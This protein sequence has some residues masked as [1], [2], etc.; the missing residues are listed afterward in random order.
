[1]ENHLRT[2]GE[3]VWAVRSWKPI[4]VLW[5]WVLGAVSA[6]AQ[7][8]TA[9]VSGTVTDQTEAAVPN[10]T[11]TV[12]NVDT[13]MAR[14]TLT[15]PRGRYEVLNLPVGRYEVSATLAGF[16]TSVRTGIE[17]TVG[18]N[19]VVDLVLQVGEV[20]QA[21]TVAGEA[22]FVETSTATVSNLVDEKRVE[23]LPLN[24][25]DLTQLT[26]LQPGVLRVPQGSGRQNVLG[27][28][29]DKLTVAG[30]R[31]TQN[32]YLLDGVSNSDYTGN[33]QGVSSAYIGAE[34]VKEFQVI[35]NNYS[36]EYWSAP[37]A[38]VSVVTKSGTN[39]LH[40]SLF[41]FLRNDNLDA[42]NFFDNALG[43]PKPEFKRNQF[44]GSLG[45]PIVRDRT[46][47]FGSYE[48]LRERLGTTGTARVPTAQTR[49]GIFPD[50]TTVTVN[51]I[52][53]PYLELYP[54]PG[55]NNAVV[56]DFN[57]GTVQ[58]SGTASQPTTDDFVAARIDHQ[59]AGE[60]A[61][62][63]SGTYNFD[64]AE[65]SPFGVLGDVTAQGLANRKHIVSMRH[66]SV[67]SPI[68]LNE[69]NFGFSFTNIQ[70]D[71]P[72]SDRDF[73]NVVYI[74]G[75][76]FVGQLN[77][78]E[79]SS[80]GYRQGAKDITQKQLTFKDGFSRTHGNH[81]L[82]FGAEINRIY[83][84]F[85]SEAQGFFGAY[86]FASLNTFLAGS[87]NRFQATLKGSDDPV[88]N[89]TQI[90]FGAY[91]QDN[92]QVRPSLTL[93]LGFRYEL[94]TVPKEVT[95]KVSNLVHFSDPEVT[96]GTFFL[97]PSLRN[98]GPRVGFAWAPGGRRWSLRGGVGVFYEYLNLYHINV[99]IV[100][101]PP[102]A[103]RGQVD[104]TD[105]R[106]AGT[107]LRFPDAFTTQQDLLRSTP[108]VNTL[109]FDQKSAYIYRW[110]LTLQREL[111]ADWVVSAGY[112]GARGLHLF[113]Q[114]VANINRWEG[115]PDQ[116]AGAKF[117][118][119]I[120]GSNRINPK[121]GEIRT[122]S[123]NG[124]SYHH[125]LALGAQKRFSRGLQLQLA[126]TLSKT[127]DQFSGT[128]SGG[129]NLP[130]TQRGMYYWDFDQARGPAAF[131]VRNNFVTNF[132]YEPPFGQNLGGV[133]GALV[134]GWQLNGV[135]SLTDGHPLTILDGNTAQRN[136]IGSN[137][138]LRA[139]L[140]P[141][142]DN[143]PVLGGPERYYDPSQFT[144]SQAGFFGTLG[145]NTLTSP[146]VATFNLSVIK[147]FHFTEES[148]LQFRAE[149]FNLFNRANFGTPD[150]TPFTTSGRADANAGRITA[151]TTKAREIQFGLR[152]VF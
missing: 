99:P 38:I 148:R 124:N 101:L 80:I 26:Y 19:A 74:P 126:Y 61:G 75:R 152:F 33:A 143:N 63:L 142:G 135:L 114:S 54:V 34:T 42:A 85:I 118:P 30:A 136:R 59:F 39:A 116:P 73:S 62:F 151:T 127:I 52:V 86:D 70:G 51:P 95:G 71:F 125:G 84:E 40:G 16:Q 81:S 9:T 150:T 13:G 92:Y 60:K 93:N 88:R 100:Q 6:G 109:E 98:F 68:S 110:S 47:F 121:W 17:L 119:A 96:L 18:R 31:S 8:T 41:E 76:K 1:M 10:T 89:L 15:G 3:Y 77:V 36:A 91:V 137:E 131:D 5:F 144:P 24:N 56:R 123:S 35:S 112:T 132:S 45:G 141:G 90:T 128:V 82:R 103:L 22:A 106:R 58:I 32:V 87:P 50:G 147:N 102:F 66:T 48:G 139:D 146:G 113:Q 21:I 117:W 25:R 129:D 108:S 12:K 145:R 67:L 65:R 28:V 2:H 130:Q 134:S 43:N 83:Y 105:A 49:Q 72:I 149:F 44:G 37:G 104:D 97:N 4:V 69:F 133:A 46:F 122:Q 64:D 11:V 140:V 27:G 29:G 94:A 14:T 20:A 79:L 111:A 57:D 7:L 138:A 53:K 78:G 115:W 120:T 107:T 23:D 55:Q